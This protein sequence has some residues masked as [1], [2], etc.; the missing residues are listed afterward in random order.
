MY[1]CMGM[2]N[3]AGHVIAGLKPGQI[4]K[5]GKGFGF[6]AVAE[7]TTEIVWKVAGMSALTMSGISLT[8]N[9][10][11]G[12]SPTEEF[13]R[14]AKPTFNARMVWFRVQRRIAW[15]AVSEK[16]DSI[17][18]DIWLLK[19]RAGKAIKRW[20]DKINSKA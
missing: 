9:D 3:R 14:K 10:G 16:W 15:R 8:C 2:G 13:D 1:G 20:A 6:P 5:I 17:G 4:I 11:A 18:S 12:V 7:P 19:Y